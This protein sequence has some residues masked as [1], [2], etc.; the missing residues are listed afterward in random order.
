[1]PGIAV[2]QSCQDKLNKVRRAIRRDKGASEALR[3]FSSSAFCGQKEGEGGGESEGQQG[4][5]AGKALPQA[6][7]GEC[8]GKR[9]NRRK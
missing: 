6:T 4:W 5:A 1:M 9:P 3:S 7:V 8:L 2:S